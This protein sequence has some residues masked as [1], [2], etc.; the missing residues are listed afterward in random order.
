MHAFQTF[1]VLISPTRQ[2]NK[3]KFIPAFTGDMIASSILL[4]EHLALRAS[5]PFSKMPLKVIVTGFTF[6]ELHH[7]FLTIFLLTITTSWRINYQIYNSFLA[8]LR[9][10]NLNVGIIDGLSPQLL[11]LIPF[12]DV[13]WKQTEERGFR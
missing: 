5:F 11:M 1:I 12:P 13:L 8:V 6:M 2:A 3:A 7:A 4:Y 10:T 9:W